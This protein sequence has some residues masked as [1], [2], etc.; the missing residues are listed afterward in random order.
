MPISSRKIEKYL[1]TLREYEALKQAIA[2]DGET[3]ERLSAFKLANVTRKCA[4]SILTGAEIGAVNRIIAVNKAANEE[5]R[6]L[7]S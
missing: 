7:L 1:E 2:D 3:P 6:K 5:V 4:Y